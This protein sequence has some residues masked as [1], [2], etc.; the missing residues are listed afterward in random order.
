MDIAKFVKPEMGAFE[1]I[2][3]I[4]NR[5]NEEY[6]NFAFVPKPLPYEIQLKNS[7]HTLVAKASMEVGRLQECVKRLPN[8]EILLRPSIAREAKSTS[9]LEGTY[10]PLQEILEGD[11]LEESQIS[12]SVKEIRNYMKAADRGLELIRTKP[13]CITVISELQGILVDGTLGAQVNQG[14]VRTGPVIIGDETRPVNEARFIP[15]PAGEI[16]IKGYYEW[17]TW[18]NAVNDISPIIKIALGHYQ[19]ETLHPYSDGNGRVGRLIVS[20]QFVEHDLLNPP[21]LNLSDWLNREKE[22]YK[23]EL[24]TLSQEGNFDRWISYFAE[25]VIGQ[26]QKEITRIEE[27]LHFKNDLLSNLISSKERGVVLKLAEGLI[28]NPVLTV[29]RIASDYQVTYPPAASAVAKLVKLGVLREV[30]G[31]K[32]NKIFLCKEVLRILER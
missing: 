14:E 32:Y 27:L 13:V 2:S 9:A 31:R 24:L 6:T 16:L 21:V 29:N 20:L 7:T 17:E 30:T 15:P 23:D 8:P 10:A 11:Y 28:A 12:N 25:A 19:F 5:R 1:A 18:I 22:K 3:G 4:N 26:V